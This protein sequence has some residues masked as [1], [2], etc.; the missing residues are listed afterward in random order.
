MFGPDSAKKNEIHYLA[1]H[2]NFWHLGRH[3]RFCGEFNPN[4]RNAI[5]VL[6]DNHI[7]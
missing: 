4:T 7:I 2:N 3:S 5:L 1:K 6:S